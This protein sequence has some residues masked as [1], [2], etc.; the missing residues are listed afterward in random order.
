VT[1][2]TGLPEGTWKAFATKPAFVSVL[3]ASACDFPITLGTS[4]V[5]FPLET[6][7]ST[8]PFFWSFSPASGLWLMTIPFSIESLNSR[9][10]WGARPA[11]RI[12][13][14]ASGSRRPSTRGTGTGL[15]AFSWS[16]IFV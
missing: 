3:T 1:V 14:F 11:A 7:M 9:A 5:S 16:W 6:V 10:T 4:T 2:S 13:F 8:L 12:L 15:L